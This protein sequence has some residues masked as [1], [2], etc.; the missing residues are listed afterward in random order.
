MTREQTTEEW[1]TRSHDRFDRI[2]SDQN[3]SM[4]SMV[5]QTEIRAVAPFFVYTALDV[6]AIF[7]IG[8]AL[9]ITGVVDPSESSSLIDPVDECAVVLIVI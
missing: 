2:G 7:R 9:I 1:D 8:L 3:R 5:Q 6:N 4:G